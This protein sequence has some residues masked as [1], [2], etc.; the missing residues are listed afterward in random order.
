MDIEEHCERTK[1]LFS[2]EY[3]DVHLWL[4]EFSSD[5][6]HSDRYKHRKHRHHIEG[7][8]EARNNFGCLGMLVAMFHITDDNEGYLPFKKEYDIDEYKD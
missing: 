2:R 6:N 1:K 5:Y 4:D 3:R 8:I 7:V